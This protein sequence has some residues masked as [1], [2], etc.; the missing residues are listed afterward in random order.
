MDVLFE[1]WDEMKQIQFSYSVNISCGVFKQ[2]NA[3]FH[4]Q[5]SM[6]IGV[7]IIFNWQFLLHLPGNL[8]R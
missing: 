5:R 6:H 7:N 1:T 4:K 8:K 2:W 3:S